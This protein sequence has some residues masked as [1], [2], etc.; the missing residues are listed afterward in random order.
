MTE[1]A[2]EYVFKIF[3]FIVAALV[4]IGIILNF[5]TIASMIKLPCLFPP[6]EDAKKCETTP[7]YESSI[8]DDILKKYCDLCWG[9]TGQ[10]NYDKD[11][12]CYVINGTLTTN[13]FSSP[14]C[15]L[16]C[17]NPAATTIYFYY[18]LLERNVS[19]EC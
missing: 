12:L 8:N 16:R 19:V 13:S 4:I 1:M 7:A 18:K 15:N 3:I 17:S 6:C 9:K 14:N 5:Q 11:C 10:V 2:M